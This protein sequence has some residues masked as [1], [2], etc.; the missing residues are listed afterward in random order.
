MSPQKQNERTMTTDEGIAIHSKILTRT[1]EIELDKLK[2]ENSVL[3]ALI[4][5]REAER[6]RKFLPVKLGVRTE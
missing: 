3:R 6:L 4:A 5:M 1:R 2:R